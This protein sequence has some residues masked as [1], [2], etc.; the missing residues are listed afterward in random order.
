M[1]LKVCHEKEQEP[2]SALNPQMSNMGRGAV[3]MVAPKMV[4][5]YKKK[6][7][8]SWSHKVQASSWLLEAFKQRQDNFLEVM[9]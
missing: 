8:Q 3:K 5:S 7:Y 4:A 1:Y 9:L 6:D 2:Y